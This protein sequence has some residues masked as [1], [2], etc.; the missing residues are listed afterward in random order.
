[1]SGQ[2]SPHTSTLASPHSASQ[3]SILAS[4]QAAS[5][6]SIYA[7]DDGLRPKTHVT[8]HIAGSAVSGEDNSS[9]ASG[10]P[11]RSC[12]IRTCLKCLQS[13]LRLVC[14][15]A[16]K[17]IDVVSCDLR[18]RHTRMANNEWI[19]IPGNEDRLDIL[20][21]KRKE[22]S[23][24][25]WRHRRTL[26]CGQQ[27]LQ[28]W[29]S[30]FAI[31][32]REMSLIFGV[33]C[34]RRHGRTGLPR[35]LLQQYS[36]VRFLSEGPHGCVYEARDSK[37]R[38]VAVRIR[39]KSRGNLL[40]LPLEQTCK[41]LKKFV[42]PRGR[43][44]SFL[45]PP[46]CH[47]K[48]LVDVYN[49]FN[50]AEFYIEV[51]EYLEGGSL[52]D[53]LDRLRSPCDEYE[54]CQ[55]FS[56]ILSALSHLHSRK[57][58]HRDVRL[59]QILLIRGAR[60]NRLREVKLSDSW[61]I[62]RIPR[63]GHL[64]DEARPVYFATSAPEVLQAGDWSE[65][66]DVW[67]A[68]CVLFSL[69]HGHPPFGGTG[70]A[71]V[72]RICTKDPEY[73]SFCEGLSESAMHFMTPFLSREPK[74]RPRAHYALEHRWLG[75][76]GGA[77]PITRARTN[78]R[79]IT[80]VK[81]LGK[82][83]PCRQHM[84]AENLIQTKPGMFVAGFCTF[85][86]ETSC[87]IDFEV[88]SSDIWF[89]VKRVVLSLWGT[90]DNPK[91]ISLSVAPR[92][93]SSFTKIN[94]YSVG[95]SSDIETT[96]SVDKPLRFLRMFLIG[97]W[98]GTRG[99]AVRKVAFYGYEVMP[100]PISF[101]AD[102]VTFR[103]G[104]E[105]HVHNSEIREADIDDRVHPSIRNLLQKGARVHGTGQRYLVYRDIFGGPQHRFTSAAV[106][107]P[108][109]PHNCVIMGAQFALRYI[110]RTPENARAPRV[111]IAFEMDH[112]KKTLFYTEELEV[113]SP[114]KVKEILAKG[115]FELPITYGVDLNIPAHSHFLVEMVF[116][117]NS[118]TIHVP[119]DIGLTLF[120][121]PELKEASSSESDED[122]SERISNK[123]GRRHHANI[124]AL[125]AR[126][127]GKG[128]E[129]DMDD[130]DGGVQ[131]GHSEPSDI[132]DVMEDVQ[133]A[134]I[135]ANMNPWGHSYADRREVP[136][137][138]PTGNIGHQSLG[139]VA[140]TRADGQ[141]S[142]T[143]AFGGAS[144]S[145]STRTSNVVWFGSAGT[146]TADT[147][148]PQ[149]PR[150]TT[151]TS[152]KA[153]EPSAESA[154]VGDSKEDSASSDEDHNASV[155]WKN[156]EEDPELATKR[157]AR[158]TC[159]GAEVR[160][161]IRNAAVHR[162]NI[163]TTVRKTYVPGH[164]GYFCECA[165]NRLPP[166]LQTCLP[167]P[168]RSSTQD[169]KQGAPMEL[170]ADGDCCPLP[171]LRQPVMEAA[172]DAAQWCLPEFAIAEEDKEEEKEKVTGAQG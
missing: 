45:L 131:M 21:M 120:Y 6:E 151:Y 43:V 32:N 75:E 91:T 52:C 142:V 48:Y 115:Y 5:K 132:S 28:R 123:K 47:H 135:A 121:V 44:R 11:R 145:G 63:D 65:K 85:M 165:L 124:P 62:A 60:R 66:A 83:P 29:K 46:R 37:R 41:T 22:I 111:R 125:K 101:D 7:K 55:V 67:S 157:R 1:M 152:P 162:A 147:L 154:S 138:F 133:T 18:A 61:C 159:I 9:D 54:A 96:L 23:D 163:R 146:T 42:I 53:R 64:F 59:A 86:G 164:D 150:L 27:T 136:A 73:D 10:N 51:S 57:L 140:D 80:K 137:Y 119:A 77:R 39:D 108:E 171:A 50:T 12:G 69:L 167:L 128:F 13:I 153:S 8:L 72:E 114:I 79:H 141:E 93:D 49:V 76:K 14:R 97:N 166:A 26:N 116:E 94:D 92:S 110:A 149:V 158:Q 2:T 172:D 4:P 56:R 78:E 31:M 24:E 19:D 155:W 89:W 84:S 169:G 160:E 95:S 122:R 126:T 144:G 102:R 118:G 170:C 68:G 161:E 25:E 17:T 99:I 58:M 134:S 3:K 81:L 127:D 74:Q 105:S 104:C 90:Q 109:L 40:H 106:L 117:N 113:E 112:G 156:A 129:L 16:D 143:S 88:G 20:K 35:R 87:R 15:V 34:C 98:G 70:Q 33:L 139:Y 130:N 148:Q 38:T 100:V 103:N 107:S 168:P 71:L 82:P 30:N 36:F